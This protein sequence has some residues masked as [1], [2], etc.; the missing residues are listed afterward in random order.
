MWN[1]EDIIIGTRSTLTSH[2]VMYYP[3]FYYKLNHIKYF[4]CNDKS[5]TQRY[6]K[7]SFDELRKDILKALN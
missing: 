7:Y 6:C 2:K 4:S 5:W 1:W 3:K